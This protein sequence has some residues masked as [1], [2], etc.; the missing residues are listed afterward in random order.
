MIDAGVNVCLGT[1]GA[2]SNNNLNMLH[3]LRTAALI[4]PLST[5]DAQSVNA[6]TVG[7]IHR[8]ITIDT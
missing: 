4:G 5:G 7:N 1:D 6:I 3:E 8:I 2:S